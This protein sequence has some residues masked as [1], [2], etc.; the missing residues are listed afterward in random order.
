VSNIASYD[1][2]RISGA[3]EK[4]ALRLQVF[5][6]WGADPQKRPITSSTRFDF[7]IPFNPGRAMNTPLTVQ[8]GDLEMTLEKFVVA[9]SM[10]RAV[11]CFDAPPT[12]KGLPASNWA[13]DAKLSVDGK[14]AIGETTLA[15]AEPD[16]MPANKLVRC[17]S[18]TV[19]QVPEKPGTANSQWTLAVTRLRLF[20]SEDRQR[21]YADLAKA[22]IVVTPYPDSGW[23]F[24]TPRNLEPEVYMKLVDR[25]M[26][27]YQT[28]VVGPW[29]F[30]F[31][32]P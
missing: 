30:T 23:S 2:S 31:K 9:P 21:V 32:L 20:G 18:Y 14:E 12:V 17:K 10:T 16:G 29:N 28:K 15:S 11:I 4:L 22:G 7:T 3:P 19:P 1:A 13:V 24:D 5:Y 6:S 27:E 25:I 8:V 26:A